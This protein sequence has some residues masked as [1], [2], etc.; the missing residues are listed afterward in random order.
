MIIAKDNVLEKISFVMIAHYV[1][2]R[3]RVFSTACLVSGA[4]IL[5]MLL[6]LLLSDLPIVV[7]ISI[8]V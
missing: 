5:F 2:N 3:Y 1:L 4:K 7:I 8:V 6:L